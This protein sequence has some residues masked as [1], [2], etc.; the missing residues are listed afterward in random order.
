MWKSHSWNA[1]GS[2]EGAWFPTTR[3]H[4]CVPKGKWTPSGPLRGKEH[5]LIARGETET[6]FRG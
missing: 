5:I 2:R 3:G 6:V 1:E 4:G